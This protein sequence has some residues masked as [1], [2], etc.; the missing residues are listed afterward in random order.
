M[1]EAIGILHPGQMGISVAASARNSGFL[2]C[3]VS[4]GRSKETRKRAESQSL[5]EFETLNDLCHECTMIFSVCPPHA[6]EE[7][8]GQVIATGFMGMYVDA[9]AISPQRVRRIGRK[10]VESGI[11]FVDGGIIGGPAWE[12]DSTWLY[13]SGEKADVAAVCFSDGPLGTVVIGDKIGSASALKMCFAAYTKGTTALLCAILAAAEQLGVREE[14]E[15]QWS[16]GGSDFAVQAQQ[17]A[18]RV[19]AKAWRFAGEMDEIA[20][21]LEGAGLPDG[22]H[23]AAGEV[24]R[25]LA[26][27]KGQEEHPAL[28][29]VLESL[30]NGGE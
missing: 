28:E 13:L 6:A 11:D 25:R 10:M 17:R 30:Q 3:W 5:F 14:L 27:F 1:S 4:E 2:V 29:D 23:R 26:H 18:R 12:P 16:R 22:F 7:L 15:M 20:D 24:Y 19:T 21:T 8:A 9:N